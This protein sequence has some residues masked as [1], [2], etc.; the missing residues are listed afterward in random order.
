MGEGEAARLVDRARRG[1]VEAWEALYL[2][3]YP[4]LLAYA[5]S[6]L[7]NLDDARE[8]VGEAIARAVAGLPRFRAE[9]NGFDAWTVGI[10]RHVVQDI[11]RDRALRLARLGAEPTHNGNRPLEQVVESEDA[12]EVLAAFKRLSR[13][14]QEILDLRVVAGLSPD[15]VATVLGRRP[16]AVRM[17]QSRALRRLRQL[18]EEDARVGE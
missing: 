13:G 4:K 14:D 10:L 9:G 7:R 17:A 2:R 15:D 6:R 3:V 18:L 1:E 12:E 5:R 16:G 11:Q 8:A